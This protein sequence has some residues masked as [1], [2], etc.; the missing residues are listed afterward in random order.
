MADDLYE[1]DYYAWTKAQAAALRARRSGANALDYDNLAEEVET[2]GRSERRACLS[3]IDNILTHFLKLAYLGGPDAPHWK[4]EIAAFRKDL[5]RDLTPSLRASLPADLPSVYADARDILA[6][7][8]ALRDVTLE[9]PADCPYT[10]ED[11]LGRGVDW[12]PEPSA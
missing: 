4:V 5:R 7:E 1:R 8:L 9:A 2:L 3:Q 12:T 11:V 6:R 10:W